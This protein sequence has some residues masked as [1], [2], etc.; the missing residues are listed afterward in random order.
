MKKVSKILLP[1]LLFF[2]LF[3]G[4]S[5][6]L[7]SGQVVTYD[8]ELQ[9][10]KSGSMYVTETIFYIF[11]EGES[12]GIYRD[13]PLDYNT[14]NGEYSIEISDITVTDE[15]SIPYNFISTSDYVLH[16]TIGSEDILVG[17]RQIYIIKYKVDNTVNYLKDFDEFYWQAT[18]NYWK[19]SLSNI[20]V[21]V[22]L[23]PDVSSESVISACYYGFY[24]SQKPCINEP[25]YSID[26]TTQLTHVVYTHSR[27]EGGEGMSIVLGVPK[28]VIDYNYTIN[29]PTVFLFVI[30]LS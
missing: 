29:F 6:A 25:A 11:G 28:G 15:N 14:D 22:V 18:S 19:T 9:L 7:A 21:S 17:D 5:D 1:I 8:I 23:P 13:I 12:H 4:S 2:I 30:I 3:F 27:L 24:G 26:T 16:L 10:N 20:K